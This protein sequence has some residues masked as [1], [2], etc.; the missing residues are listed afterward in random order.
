MESLRPLDGALNMPGG[1]FSYGVQHRL[2]D[3]A[4]KM[5]FDEAS[6]QLER[7]TGVHVSKRAAERI[8][9][10]VSLD[11]DAFYKQQQRADDETE[12]ESQNAL[13]VLSS[14]GKGVVVRKCDL[15]EETQKRA[16]REKKTKRKKRLSPGQKKN[17]K[18]MAVV[19]AVFT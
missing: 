15:R 17:R 13:L 8:I 9:Q 5:S 1:L 11:F 2:I 10:G 3:N 16:E 19:G 7:M 12:E 6:N 18:R 4:I 14:D